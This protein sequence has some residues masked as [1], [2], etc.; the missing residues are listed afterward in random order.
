M[1]QVMQN[2]SHD[3]C[4]YFHWKNNMD[5]MQYLMLVISATLE[6]YIGRTMVLG[7][8][9]QKVNKIP[10]QPVSWAWLSLSTISAMWKLK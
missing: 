9:S 4:N 5:W 2:N 10:S 1:Y 7:Q 6:E 3:H 8:L